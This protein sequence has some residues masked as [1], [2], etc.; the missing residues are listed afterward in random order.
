MTGDHLDV[1][2]CGHRRREIAPVFNPP[3][4]A[5][6]VVGAFASYIK[7][8]ADSEV[9]A[10]ERPR[11]DVHEVVDAAHAIEID[12]WRFNQRDGSRGLFER[13]RGTED[14]GR[15]T[16][17]KNVIP[18]DPFACNHD[19]LKWVCLD[20]LLGLCCSRGGRQS[21]QSEADAGA[22]AARA[23]VRRVHVACW[24]VAL[25]GRFHPRGPHQMGVSRLLHAKLSLLNQLYANLL[26]IHFLHT[27]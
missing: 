9:V 22:Y 10:G 7:C 21:D 27:Y 5:E 4:A 18:V 15:L 12:Q 26:E 11:R 16:V 17:G 25:Q 6:E 19:F 3:E 13:S 8:A 2:R 20:R 23:A 14:A 24:A 1:L